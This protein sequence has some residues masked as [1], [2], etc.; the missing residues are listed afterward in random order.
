MVE[1]K[2]LAELIAERQKLKESSIKEPKKV[3]VPKGPK[4]PPRSRNNQK[5]IIDT[6]ESIKTL[7][8]DNHI[9]VNEIF[10]SIS[11]FLSN[12]NSGSIRT[13][14]LA[15]N[16]QNILG[17]V[18]KKQDVLPSDFALIYGKENSFDIRK[19]LIELWKEN[20]LVKN[21]HGHYT[22][23]PDLSIDVFIYYCGEVNEEE[24]VSVLKQIKTKVE[25]RGF[26]AF[27]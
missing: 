6:L 7:I 13:S 24:Y 22:I 19:L 16:K 26:K 4:G 15:L 20:Y 1:E 23:N 14:S 18:Y 3:K 17:M 11:I 10:G 12:M 9:R 5:Q 27:T 21:T 2:S 25:A 8:T